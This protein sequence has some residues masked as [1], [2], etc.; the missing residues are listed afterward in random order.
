M[1]R[2]TLEPGSKNAF[3]AISG[4]SGDGAT[5]QWRPDTDGDSSS[6]RTLVVP[7]PPASIK[8]VR[9]GDT[10]TGYVLLDGQWQQQ[11]ES[12][13]IVMGDDVYVGLAITSHKAGVLATVVIDEVSITTPNPNVA[14]YPNPA[15][16]ATEVSR[17]PTL[18]WEPG[19]TAASHDVYFG[20]VSSPPL[21]GNQAET[22]YSPPKLDKGKTYYWRIDE[23]E[24]DGTTKHEG[25][26]WSFTVTTVGR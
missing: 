15:D 6:S 21:V 5:F 25:P 13:T 8:L 12:A 23:V 18:S 7:P 17:T 4:G 1:I 3:V 9:V 26:V 11:G 16:G 20:D 14:A 24:A 22:S 2:E 10:F 19:A